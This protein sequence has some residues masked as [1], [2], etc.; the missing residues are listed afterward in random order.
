MVAWAYRSTSF[1][2]TTALILFFS[3]CQNAN[4]ITSPASTPLKILKN[5]NEIK[6]LF[7]CPRLLSTQLIWISHST[8]LIQLQ[9]RSQAHSSHPSLLGCQIIHQMRKW[10]ETGTLMMR[11]RHLLEGSMSNSGLKA[12]FNCCSHKIC[13]LVDLPETACIASLIGLLWTHAPWKSSLI[14]HR[15]IK[16]TYWSLYDS[17]RLFS[18]LVLCM[19]V[20][21]YAVGV[22]NLNEYVMI[23]M[24]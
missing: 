15:K 7:Y 8:P 6:Q 19:H 2:A 18:S 1:L 13:F 11:Q 9:L 4:T 16:I 5:P 12:A 3:T 23:I 14:L 22:K 17:F 21:V 20:C 10:K 24:H